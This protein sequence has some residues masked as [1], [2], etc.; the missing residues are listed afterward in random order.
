MNYS[1][2]FYSITSLLLIDCSKMKDDS[3]ISQSGLQDDYKLDRN[4]RV[5]DKNEFIED[6]FSKVLRLFPEN[7]QEYQLAEQ[8]GSASANNKNSADKCNKCK[9]QNAEPKEDKPFFCQQHRCNTGVKHPFNFTEDH[10]SNTR[11]KDDKKC[12]DFNGEQ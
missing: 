12:F 2:V 5:A 10:R 9:T 3:L 7:E 1:I 11:R 8:G 4:N 6:G